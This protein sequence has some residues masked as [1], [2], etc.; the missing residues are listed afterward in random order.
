MTGLYVAG[1]KHSRFCRSVEL[2]LWIEQPRHR[3][4]SSPLRTV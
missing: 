1:H 4:I 3:C 2:Q